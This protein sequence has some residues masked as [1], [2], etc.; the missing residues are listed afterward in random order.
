MITK[1]ISP[2]D[3]DLQLHLPPHA[4]RVHRQDGL[5][6]QVG[7]GDHRELRKAKRNGKPCPTASE[8]KMLKV[9]S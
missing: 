5:R 4:A 7:G 1:K 6:R 2:P 3:P 9:F 8:W